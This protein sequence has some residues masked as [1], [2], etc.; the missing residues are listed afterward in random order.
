MPISVLVV[1]AEQTLCLCILFKTSFF[2]QSFSDPY[3]LRC[4]WG[5]GEVGREKEGTTLLSSK[6][7]RSQKKSHTYI[8]GSTMQGERDSSGLRELAVLLEDPDSISSI[9]SQLTTFCNSSARR[10]DSLIQT[11]HHAQNKNN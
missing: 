7:S 4:R 10:E 6:N 3:A 1:S 8:K 2:F 9:S 5:D 11:E